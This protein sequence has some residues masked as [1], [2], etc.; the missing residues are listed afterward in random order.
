VGQDVG[1]DGFG[2]VGQLGDNPEALPGVMN[3]GDEL[4]GHGSHGP[5]FTQEVQGKVGVEPALEVECQVQ[6]EQR[7]CGHRSVVVAFFLQG[8]VPSRIGR[9]AGGTT[10]MVLVVP[11]DL[12]LQ[13]GVGGGVVGNFFV[14]QQGDQAVLQGAEAAF[15][16][17]F[18]RSIWGNAM[19]RAQ[20]REGALELGVS[21]EPVGGG[22]VTEERQAVGVKPG[23]R[24]VAFQE[25]TEMGEVRPSGVAGGK[26]AAE[27]FAGVIIER[28]DKAGITVGRPP[29]MRRGV[30]LPEFSDSG[31]LPAAAGFGA[32]FEGGNQLGEVL[33]DVGGDSRAGAMEVELAGQFVGQER[34]VQRLAMGQ[35]TGQEIVCRL[36]PRRSM[37]AAGRLGR[38]GGLVVEPL[39]AQ[40]VELR[41][42]EMQTLGGGQRVEL[43]GVKGG[44]HFL[45][46]EG[47]NAMG[48]LLLFI[49]GRS[50]RLG[51]GG[52]QVCRSFSLGDQG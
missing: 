51:R 3:N 10:G 22:G 21:V 38:K 14:G 18:G 44:Q 34:E 50:V 26:G 11:G 39:V 48:Q 52:R 12:R 17:A 30:M 9:Q 27:D 35:A 7:H 37:V 5:V 8:Q 40:A 16:F 4:I 49:L 42:T 15:D 2:W 33:A 25:R 31:A 20:R 6:V 29:R 19:G 45:D 1:P 47:R 13:Q 24:A 41:G 36:R 23:G 32:T 28:E 46:V 43:T